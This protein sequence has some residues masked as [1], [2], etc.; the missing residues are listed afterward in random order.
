MNKFDTAMKEV[1]DTLLPKAKHLAAGSDRGLKACMISLLQPLAKEYIDPG[2]K[3]AKVDRRTK[4]WNIQLRIL[5]AGSG[6]DSYH[7]IAE[8][9]VEV[10]KGH[11][12]AVKRFLEM[13]TDAHGKSIKGVSE[14]QP[15]L[16]LMRFTSLRP[17]ISR[18]GGMAT[19]N[20]K[21]VLDNRIYSCILRV[22][23]ANIPLDIEPPE[24]QS[25]E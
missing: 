4:K 15:A 7:L 23:R 14:L 1:F 16:L 20:T 11:A 12:G 17:T 10:V 5:E 3:A 22:S 6:P 25:A 21:Y 2:V 9:D 13:V 19:L 18:A 24:S 8:S